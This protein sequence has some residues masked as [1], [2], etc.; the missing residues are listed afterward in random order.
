MDG[1]NY[2]K[3][4]DSLTGKSGSPL[5]EEK[6]LAYMEGK[7]TPEERHEVEQWLAEDGLENDALEGMQLL[8]ATEAKSS[9]QSI[10]TRLNDEVAKGRRKPKRIGVDMQTVVAIVLILVLA[11]AAFFVYKMLKK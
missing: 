6:L 10:N 8:N 3:L 2:N 7:L 9:V 5:S 1:N 11:I 4:R